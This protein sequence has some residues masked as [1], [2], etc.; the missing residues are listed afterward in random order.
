MKGGPS[1]TGALARGQRRLQSPHGTP[2]PGRTVSPGRHLDTGTHDLCPSPAPP[3]RKDRLWMK[4]PAGSFHGKSRVF[5]FSKGTQ[6]KEVTP[7]Y[8]IS[9]N[10]TT[11]ILC[12]GLLCMRGAGG[13]GRPR[14]PTLRD[15]LREPPPHIPPPTPGREADEASG[16]A[17][18]T[19]QHE[20]AKPSR[21]PGHADDIQHRA[22]APRDGGDTGFH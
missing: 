17:Q 16:G 5:F 22:C 19:P 9:D 12:P 13:P 14:A 3:P 1:G 4:E 10:K 11:Q 15:S 6:L 2:G 21:A 20:A 7:P 18:G 8:F